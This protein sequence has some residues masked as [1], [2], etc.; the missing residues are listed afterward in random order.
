MLPVNTLWSPLLLPMH[1]VELDGSYLVHANQSI[2]Y[3]IYLLSRLGGS[4]G[5]RL[6][7][8]INTKSPVINLLPTFLPDVS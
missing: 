8:Q 6:V 7:K 1:A 2:N 3:G 5:N 4:L